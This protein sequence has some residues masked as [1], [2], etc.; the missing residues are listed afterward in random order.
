MLTVYTED[1]RGRKSNRKKIRPLLNQ[2]LKLLYVV[3]NVEEFGVFA[4]LS[5]VAQRAELSSTNS[6]FRVARHYL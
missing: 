6:G 4:V 2:P 3:V 1:F 5:Q